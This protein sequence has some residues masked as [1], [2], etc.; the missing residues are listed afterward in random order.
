MQ[1]IGI[2]H[3]RHRHEAREP[4]PAKPETESMKAGG[5]LLKVHKYA[6]KI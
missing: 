3:A 5:G 6:V 1:G 4:K 2:K